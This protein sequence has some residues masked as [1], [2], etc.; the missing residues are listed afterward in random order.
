MLLIILRQCTKDDWDTILDLRNAFY[1]ESFYQQNKPITKQEHYEYMIKQEKNPNFHQWMAVKD[2]EVVGYIRILDSDISI[3]VLRQYH[4]KGIG[5][6]MLQLVEKEAKKLGIKKLRGLV[7]TN[8]TNSQNIFQ[9][10]NY[11]LK[12][13]WFE[14]DL[15]S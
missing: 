6:I 13:Y 15:N 5:T 10:N 2:N 9:K 1:E 14:K 3:L 8:N 4:N 12:M 11:E 7:R